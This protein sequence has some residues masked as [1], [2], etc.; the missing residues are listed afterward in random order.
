LQRF[1]AGEDSVLHTSVDDAMRTMA[2]VEACYESSNGGG[3]PIP[4]SK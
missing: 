2:V 4:P 1:V 3:T